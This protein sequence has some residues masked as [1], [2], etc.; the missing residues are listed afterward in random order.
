MFWLANE[1]HSFC[2][3]DI[4][5]YFYLL[6]VNNNCS[7]KESFKRNNSKIESDLGIS[8]NTL[9][10]ARNRLKQARLIDFKTVNGSPNVSYWLL[11]SSNFDKVSDEVT[12]EVSDEVDREVLS[13]KDKLNKTKSNPLLVSPLTG[14]TIEERKQVFYDSLKGFVDKYPKEML[15]K[16]FDYW[17]EQNSSGK[18]MKFEMQK[19]FEISKRLT[20]WSNNDKIFS[21]NET[22]KHSTAKPTGSDF[23]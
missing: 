7:W 10:N 19:T 12:N 13:S 8:F 9:K 16:F 14:K 23:D 1:E 22:I 20:Y 17:S 2:T 11:T 6:K 3:T 4:A 18:K 15:R 5:L 21:K